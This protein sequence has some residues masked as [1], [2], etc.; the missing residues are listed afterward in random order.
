MEG[1]SH[2]RR[3]RIVGTP[4]RMTVP[5]FILV[6][7]FIML[8]LSLSLEGHECVCV[9]VHASVCVHACAC[10]HAHIHM[11]M[12]GSYICTLVEFSPTRVNGSNTHRVWHTSMIHLKPQKSICKSP[13]N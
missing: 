13:P 3:D 6:K 12:S 10:A 1:V 8:Y 9:C 2:V 11:H 5:D 4:A 7:F